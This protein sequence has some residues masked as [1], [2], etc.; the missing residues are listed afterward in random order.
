MFSF[1][2]MNSYLYL[3]GVKTFCFCLDLTTIGE[4]IMKAKNKFFEEADKQSTDK[5]GG[6]GCSSNSCSE[7]EE[8][9]EISDTK[10][11]K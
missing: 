11:S 3:R 10:V 4:N 7:Y 2:L 5:K 6:C 9:I 8:E 1:Y